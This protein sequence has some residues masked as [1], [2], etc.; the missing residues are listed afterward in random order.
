[1]SRKKVERELGTSRG[2]LNQSAVAVSLQKL[3]SGT[4]RAARI[5]DW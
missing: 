5:F 3:H 1:M 2:N 4:C